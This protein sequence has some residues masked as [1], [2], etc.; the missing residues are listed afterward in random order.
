MAF[1]RWKIYVP[2]DEPYVTEYFRSAFDV[3]IRNLGVFLQWL[4]PGD[5]A[6]QNSPIKFIDSFF[7]VTEVITRLEDAQ[8]KGVQ[9]N[10]EHDAAIARFWDYLKKEPSESPPGSST[11]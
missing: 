2:T 7:P 10:A 5:V 6:Y 9:W 3:D 1:S 11:S 8:V 4:L